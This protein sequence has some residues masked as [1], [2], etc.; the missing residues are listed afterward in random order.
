FIEK[1]VAA[2]RD[3]PEIDEVVVVDNNSK[4]RTAELATAAGAR[5]VTETRQ[6]YGFASQRALTECTT[7]LIFIVEPDGTFVANDVHKF[8]AYSSEFDVVIGT[9]TS[10]TC[11]WSGANMGYAL[12]Y[13]NWAVAKLLEY[14]HNGP[15]LTD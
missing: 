2:F 14:L 11:I 8:L 7:D 10:W 12:R 3:I 5:V 4:D 9:R 6:G 1:A 15:C 13:G